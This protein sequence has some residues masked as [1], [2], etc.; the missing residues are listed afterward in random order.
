M[1]IA[2]LNAY[3]QQPS[4]IFRILEATNHPFNLHESPSQPSPQDIPSWCRCTNCM[5]MPSELEKRCCNQIP[6]NC[7]SR[8]PV[9]C[10]LCTS[11]LVFE[12]AVNCLFYK[13]HQF[14]TCIYLY[15]DDYFLFFSNCDKRKLI[16]FFLI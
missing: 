2:M 8:L 6:R 9:S 14:I 11:K 10:S 15:S 16:N 13:S 12:F 3:H 1:R 7:H 5:E 4:F